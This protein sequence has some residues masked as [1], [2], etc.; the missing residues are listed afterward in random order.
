MITEEEKQEIIGLAVEKALL[1]IP[2][3]VGNLMASQAMMSK[4]N[5][6]FYKDYPE[7]KDKKTT[8]ASV[9]EMIDGRDPTAKYK[10]ILKEAVPEIR[11]R[12]SLTDTLDTKNVDPRPS[13]DFRDFNPDVKDLDPN[14]EI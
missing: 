6:K 14:G 13:R 7:F 4:L 12:I 11:K 9:I 10:D 8:V 5:S 1:M 2:E 3:V